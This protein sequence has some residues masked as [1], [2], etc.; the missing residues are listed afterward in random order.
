MRKGENGLGWT[1]N[2]QNKYEIEEY[3]LKQFLVEDKD[4]VLPVLH[5][6]CNALKVQKSK[7]SQTNSNLQFV[8]EKSI[9]PQFVTFKNIQDLF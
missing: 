8:I 3:W 6:S 1:G 4:V 5:L 7:W 9:H 2:K